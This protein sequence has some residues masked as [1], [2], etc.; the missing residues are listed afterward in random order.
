MENNSSHTTKWRQANKERSSQQRK[1]YYQANKERIRQYQKEHY[2]ANKERINQR[3]R[4]WHDAN[5][6]RVSLYHKEWYQANKESVNQRNK[7]NRPRYK[8]TYKK[9]YYKYAYGLPHGEFEA[10]L[11]AQNGKCAI[12]EKILTDDSPPYLDHCHETGNARG[13]LCQHC[14]S[15]I[16]FLK[17]SPIIVSK[18]LAYLNEYEGKECSA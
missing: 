1:E 6:E 7:K 5:K 2:Q 12:C 15:G 9:R 11:Q 16:G 10:M 4:T 3:G 8:E 14:N 17:D 18:A 13:I